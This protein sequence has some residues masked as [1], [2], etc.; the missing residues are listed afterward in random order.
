MII[1]YNGSMFKR[2]FN[3]QDELEPG[4][5]EI[6]QAEKLLASAQPLNPFFAWLSGAT[7]EQVAQMTL[8]SCPESK[9]D[10]PA[11]NNR[12]DWAW[13][14]EDSERASQRS[15]VWDCRFMAALVRKM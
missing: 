5:V 15:M 3:V 4:N 8:A 12:S 6:K 10:L 2:Y 7:K 13:Q 14:R 9:S 11:M 1:E